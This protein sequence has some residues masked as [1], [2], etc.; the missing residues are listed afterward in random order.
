MLTPNY[1]ENVSNELVELYS[2]LEIDIIT[3]MARRVKRLGTITEAT[4]WQA[5]MYQEAGLI[6][7]NV[8]KILAQYDK[9]V[10]REITK[11]FK[12]SIEKSVKS[13]NFIFSAGGYTPTQASEQAIEAAIDKTYGRLKNLTMTTASTAEQQFIQKATQA[14]IRVSSGAFDYDKSYRMAINELAAQNIYTVEY[15]NG[16][17]IK[18]SIEGAVRA[19]IL[20]GINQTATQI[21]KQNCELL[22][23]DLVE[24]SAHSGARPS[25]AVWQGKIYSLTGKTKGYPL[26]AECHPG[27]ADGIGGV[28]CRHSYYPYTGGEPHYTSK[29]L[30]KLD[31]RVFEYNGKKYTEYEAEQVQRGIE[32]NI[33]KYKRVFEANK[34]TGYYDISANNK[35]KQWQAEARSFIKQTGLT[36]DVL[37]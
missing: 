36:R 8:N 24:V 32:R 16:K 37:S 2:Q 7:G 28:N 4:E 1:L 3:D 9:T 15:N 22:G 10:R 33:R 17:V 34:E 26:F 5:R 18:R 25:H 6:R 29:D 19:N 30:E 27:E 21:T 12:D 20:T 14:Y 23:V 13:D 31:S 35:I 11:A